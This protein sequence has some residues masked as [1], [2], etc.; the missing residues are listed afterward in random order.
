MTKKMMLL[1]LAAVSAAMFALPSVASAGEPEVHC[2]LSGVKGKVCGKFTSHGLV[3]VLSTTGN[4]TVTCSTNTGSG[5]Y[6][7]TKTGTIKLTFSGCKESIFGS[8]CNSTG[9]ASGVI[10]TT[11]S[12]F[13]NIYLTHTKTTPGVLVTP[14]GSEHFASFSCFGEASKHVVKGNGVIGHLSSPACGGTSKTL[15]LDFDAIS[16]GQ[17]RF[18]TITGTGTP[19]DLNDNGTTAA[20]DAHGTVTTAGPATVTC[21]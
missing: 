13:H 10:V 12:V 6:T 17:Q 8:S 16:H 4:L 9:S 7:N 15:T 5:T 2:E 18:K 14:A 3:S 1:A 11:E 21:V 20:M 19:Y